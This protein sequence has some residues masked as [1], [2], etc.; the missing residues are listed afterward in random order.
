M[1]TFAISLILLSLGKFKDYF[2]MS[3]NFLPPPIIKH[4]IRLFGQIYFRIALARL[5][6]LQIFAF[7]LASLKMVRNNNYYGVTER[8]HVVEAW[9]YFGTNIFLMN[10][11]IAEARLDVRETGCV[12]SRLKSTDFL[13]NWIILYRI[14]LIY[15]LFKISMIC[16]RFCKIMALYGPISDWLFRSNFS[17]I[18]VS[19]S[20]TSFS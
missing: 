18:Y 9:L 19:Y 16:P 13:A 15:A 5:T 7:L 1:K 12:K 2:G 6:G 17:E 14:G 8:T 3:V 4:W 10:F 20:I 11:Q